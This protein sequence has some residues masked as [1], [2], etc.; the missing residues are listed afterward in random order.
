MTLGGLLGEVVRQLDRAGVDWMLTGSLAST[1]YGEPR[2]TLDIDIVI[3]PEPANLERLVDG[4]LAASF[5][6]DRDAAIEALI[7]RRQFNAV[8]PDATKVD[9]IIRRDRPFSVEE[10]GRRTRADLLGAA[11]FIATVEDMVIVKL[12]WAA[13]TG[14]ERQLRDVSAMVRVAGGIDTAY[15]ERWTDA[16]GLRDAWHRIRDAEPSS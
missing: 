14:S 4:L 11:G 13:A 6:V 10:F 15:V 7:E 8:G 12:E 9:F 1:Y 16:L 3:D 2:A 5:Y